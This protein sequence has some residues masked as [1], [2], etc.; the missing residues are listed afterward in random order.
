MQVIHVELVTG[1]LNAIL[2]VRFHYLRF[3][4]HRSLEPVRVG[5]TLDL[6]DDDQEEIGVR[7]SMS[8][9][10]SV[11]GRTTVNVIKLALRMRD[12]CIENA[13]SAMF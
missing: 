9:K 11:K 8:M 2:A 7:N 3:R 1:K 13:N 6:V 10:W 12:M 4:F 5:Y